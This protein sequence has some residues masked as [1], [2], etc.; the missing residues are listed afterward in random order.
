MTEVEGTGTATGSPESQA[1]E[2]LQNLNGRRLVV[3]LDYDGTLSPIAPR[4]EDALLPAA[5]RDVLDRLGARWPT[6]VISGRSLADAR[7]LVGLDQL[8]Y[9]GN[10]GLEIE[11]PAGSG[12]RRNLAEGF[13]PDVAAAA[14][15]LDAALADVEGSL[16]ENKRYSLSV[17]YRLVAP[18]QVPSVESAV[19][20]TVARH[21][22]LNKRLGK[23]VFELRPNLAWD[24]GKAV[25]WV[26]ETIDEQ[27]AGLL[28]VYVGDDVTDEDAFA[29]LAGD[30]VGVLV[31][32]DPRD[33]AATHRLVDTDEARRFLACLAEGAGV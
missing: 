17:H 25:R 7:G 15:E 29:A 11:G 8:F 12:I 3:L 23:K 14:A 18:E 16:V 21:P 19:D 10:H 28:P 33:T 5:T 1:G 2:I 30:G 13:V 27:G 31:S 4:P 24:K 22:T 20:A 32:E 6:A 9:A 26:L